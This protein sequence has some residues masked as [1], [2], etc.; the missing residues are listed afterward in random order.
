MAQLARVRARSGRTLRER[1]LAAGRMR[2]QHTVRIAHQA[3]GSRVGDVAAR[4]QPDRAVGRP[5][6][7]LGH[8]NGRPNDDR[9]TVVEHAHRTTVA[10]V[11]AGGRDVLSERDVAR[12]RVG[13]MDEH[14]TTGTR[15]VARGRDRAAQGQADRPARLQ[16]H[17]ATRRGRRA[18][19]R[20][21]RLVHRQRVVGR[22][23]TRTQRHRSLAAAPHR[24]DTGHRTH[25]G[26]IGV[27]R[28]HR[29]GG[30]RRHRVHRQPR[31]IQVAHAAVRTGRRV[32][33]ERHRRQLM[34]HRRVAK[35]ARTRARHR[36]ALRERDLAPGRVR[37]QLA[38][39][40]THQ[41]RVGRVG[42]VAG[43]I[44]TDCPV[45]RCARARHV[46]R[47]IQADR[48]RLVPHRH[49]TAVA[50]RTGRARRPTLGVDR[51]GQR[52]DAVAVATQMVDEHITGGRVAEAV[53]S[54]RAG[55]QRDR[56]ARLQHH[57][58]TRHIGCARGRGDR[59][60]YRQHT[61]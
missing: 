14:R 56:T 23:H 39:R 47:A 34:A 7:R 25:A 58:P 35:L 17:R 60:G 54:D 5:R 55:A 29:R 59:V 61:A 53:R 22:R 33:L 27:G 49:R 30:P 37:A 12:H 43:R 1:D 26:G 16:H 24:R 52:D 11:A 36:R 6:A 42:D 13:V 28:R 50:V 57:R 51:P 38:V 40:I 31:A 44:Q 45:R 2:A 15:R 8:I 32:R 9:A 4:L 21:D 3:A 19:A 10:R 41:A 48:T 20:V 18:R 46:E